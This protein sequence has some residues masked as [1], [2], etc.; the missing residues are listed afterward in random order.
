MT[1]AWVPSVLVPRALMDDMRKA[2]KER[3]KQR[4]A[5]RLNNEAAKDTAGCESIPDFFN[6]GTLE[7]FWTLNMDMPQDHW[8]PWNILNFNI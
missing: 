8:R 1:S 7:S 2:I 5:N 3:K 4:K 6:I